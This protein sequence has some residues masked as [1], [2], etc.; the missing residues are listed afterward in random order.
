[1]IALRG[2]QG[3]LNYLNLFVNRQTRSGRYTDLYKQWVGTD[4]GAPPALSAAGVYR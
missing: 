3:L 1:L 4:A 2:E